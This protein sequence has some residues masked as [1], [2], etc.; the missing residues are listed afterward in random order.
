MSG[1]IEPPK[2]PFK[3]ISVRKLH[4]TFGAQ[5]SGIDFSSPLSDEVFA[6]V[7]AAITKVSQMSYTGLE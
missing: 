7:L 5:I 1:L 6:E 3:Q 2:S 4:P